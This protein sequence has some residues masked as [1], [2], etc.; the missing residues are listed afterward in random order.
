MPKLAASVSGMDRLQLK[1]KRALEPVERGVA[2]LAEFVK[3]E[4]KRRAKPHA[5]D[6]GSLGNVVK[7]S[8]AGEGAK[9]SAA[10]DLPRSIYWLGTTVE[11]G[12]SPGKAPPVA[13][14][15]R[16]AERHGYLSETDIEATASIRQMS[17][18]F[19]AG[20]VSRT[21]WK[22][23]MEIKKHGTKGIHFM[24]GAAEAGRREAPRFLAKAAQ[25]IERGFGE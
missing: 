5:A 9:L 10:V 12:R 23:A 7:V 3:Q 6:K 13:A 1:L 2:E 25:A 24:A 18:G 11:E 14:I 21:A 22:L 15:G 20:H 17:K 19:L 8:F 4:A 16:W